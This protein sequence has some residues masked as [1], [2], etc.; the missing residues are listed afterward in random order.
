[1]ENKDKII[2]TILFEIEIDSYDKELT[3]NQN[4]RKHINNK[5]LNEFASGKTRVTISNDMT[6]IIEP[7]HFINLYIISKRDPRVKKGIMKYYKMQDEAL[8]NI[9]LD[10]PENIA[11]DIHYQESFIHHDKSK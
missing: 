11:K 6:M 10:R 8:F 7:E 3:I 1:M 9:W 2:G 5:M 4:L